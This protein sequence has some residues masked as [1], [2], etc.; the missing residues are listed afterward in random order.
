[1]L[2]TYNYY[3]KNDI[4]IHHSSGLYSNRQAGYPAESHPRIEISYVLSGKLTYIVNGMPCRV[5]AGDLV[6]VGANEL[7]SLSIDNSE[8]YE[9]IGVQFLPKLIPSLEGLNLE[10]A[11]SNA[12]SYRHVIP[13]ELVKKSKIPKHMKKL[14][15]CIAL[16][17]PYKDT[18]ILCELIA[19]IAEIHRTSN[20][21]FSTKADLLRPASKKV[22]ELL[23]Q[24]IE[25]VNANLT[26]PITAE[27]TAFA[28][29]ISTDYLYHFFKEQ[30]G[31]SFHV[32]VQNQKMKLASIMLQQGYSAQNT[33]TYLG[34]EHYKT[35][36]M[37]YKRVFR[38]SPTT[39]SQHKFKW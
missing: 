10:S 37:Q 17:P 25:H 11:F 14:V 24:V 23:N 34:Y 27:R 31:V 19:L 4:Y 21:L 9:R 16:Q 20:L 28:L 15:S 12:Y 8:P 7:H 36:F 32:Y 30:M 26:K 2:K 18:S 1:M 38:A 39:H 33:A 22:S 6:V 35:F 3:S 29:G 13:N 5:E